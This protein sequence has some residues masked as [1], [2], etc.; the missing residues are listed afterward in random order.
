MLETS[1]LRPA[2]PR[3]LVA[4]RGGAPLTAPVSGNVPAAE[5]SQLTFMIGGH[6][7]GFPNR[8]RLHSAM[9]YRGCSP[10]LQTNAGT[11]NLHHG[12][13][14]RSTGPCPPEPKE[15]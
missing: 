13:P 8:R 14:A 1:T 5:H 12:S 7:E 3:R 9:R 4:A 6:I 15:G 10:S 2:T 11:Y